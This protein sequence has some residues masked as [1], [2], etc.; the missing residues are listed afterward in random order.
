VRFSTFA[1]TC[2]AA[3]CLTLP[4]L[5]DSC[6]TIPGNLVSNCGF[7]DGTYTFTLPFPPDQSDPSVP[8]SWI[9]DPGF[10]EGY[11]DSSGA[12]DDVVTASGTDYLVIGT[13]QFFPPLASL[14]QDLTDVS[15]VTYDG[16]ISG[17]GG[18]GSG[19]NV[20][21]DGSPVSLDSAGSFS[22]IGSGIDQLSLV[23]TGG[24]FDVSDVVVAPAGV[25]AVPEARATFLIPAA[26]LVCVV[27]L[28]TRRRTTR[29]LRTSPIL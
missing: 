18:S 7:E 19:F 15:G 9:P 16:S 6:A 23:A 28:S 25:A 29:N 3:L 27:W 5:A 10:V 17:G 12:M 22:F 20:L 2:G 14:S 4:G 21:I 8:N 24:P 11:V 13:G 26:L 1:F